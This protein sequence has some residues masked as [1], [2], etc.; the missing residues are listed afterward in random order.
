MAG[1]NYSIII[2]NGTIIDGS[3][4]AGYKSDVG[5]IDGTIKTIGDLSIEK[6]DIKIDAKNLLVCP[7]FIDSHCHTDIGYAAEFPEVRGKIM[8]G[9]TTDVCGL[10]ST[11]YAPVGEGHLDEFLK[12]QANV[13]AGIKKSMTVA[14]LIKETDKKGNSTNMV[15]FAGNSNVRIHG[16]GYENRAASDEEMDRMKEL[17][18]SAMEDGAFGLSSGLTY[19]PSQFASTEELIELCKVIAPFGGI[20][21]S[22]MRNE[23]NELV[24]SVQEVIEI[25]EKS[26]CKGH[27]SHL[28][29]AGTKN[30]GKVKECLKLIE[31]ANNRGVE[32][33]F[34]VYPY[35]AG[36][37]D[38]SAVLPQW[39]LSEGFGNDF[40]ILKNPET[41]KKIEKDLE[42]EDWENIVLQCGYDKIFIGS[43]NNLSQYEGKNISQIA[44]ELNI[45]ELEVI[46]KVL[47]DSKAQAT[48]IY[49]IISEDD[50]RL[51][52][53]SPYCCIG[54]DAY[55]RDYSG[56][57]KGG[58]PHPRNFGGMPRFIKKYVLDEKL[59]SIEEGVRKI[60]GFPAKIFRIPNRGL[61]QENKVA[62]ITIINPMTIEE[63]G[64][65]LNPATK[66][67]GIE[68][69][70]I[71]GKIAVDKGEFN[72]IR[73][74]RMLKLNV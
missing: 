18:K 43:A 72:D 56:A 40:E 44:K 29:A 46:F 8:Q 35:T 14:E 7:G 66:P 4:K 71:E 26:G 25:T 27:C 52:M 58:K 17:L 36:S 22:H 19:V 38:L 21:N 60:T 65:Y 13:L 64:T 5:I 67:N 28:K 2:E 61:I 20:Y 23:G 48:I 47:I 54:T 69:V 1:N 49:Y 45:T 34:D 63:T 30:H 6:A 10:C 37:I 9:V 59:M 39:V 51:L 33:N 32:V 50:L 62:D 73:A 70:I 31:E 24:K 53:Q 74:G 16:V 12:R 15:M 68:Y 3:G 41:I 42:R 11:S 55:A 57:T